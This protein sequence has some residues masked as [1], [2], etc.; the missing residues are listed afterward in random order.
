MEPWE[1]KRMGKEG[2]KGIKG[3]G[4][5]ETERKGGRG[6]MERSGSEEGEEGGEFRPIAVSKVGAYDQ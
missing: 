1:G 2:G 3:R 5:E 4:E 6:R